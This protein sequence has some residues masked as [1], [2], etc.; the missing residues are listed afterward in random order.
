[1]TTSLILELYK[2]LLEFL[3]GMLGWF[4][5][6]KLSFGV[7]LEKDGQQLGDATFV[8]DKALILGNPK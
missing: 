7:F 3:K 2:S 4:S 6:Q 5:P 1:M 8:L